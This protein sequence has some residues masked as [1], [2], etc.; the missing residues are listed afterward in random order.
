MFTR[1]TIYKK[2]LLLI[3]LPLVVQATFLGLLIRSQLATLASQEWAFHTKQVIA[4]VSDVYRILSDACSAIGAEL[5]GSSPSVGST[6]R[7]VRQHVLMEID[8]L[9]SLVSDNPLQGMRVREFAARAEP[10][11]RWLETQ[12]QLISSGRN[13][14][15]RKRVQVGAQLLE[16]LRSTMRAIL[17][18]EKSLDQKRMEDLRRTTTSSARTAVI[19]GGA[20]LASTLA[21]SLVF[22]HGLLKRLA[23]LRDNARRFSEG[24]DLRVPMI[25]RDE[26]SD[27][28]RAFH[29][30]AAKLNQQKQENDLF[31]YSVSHDLRSPLVNLQGFSEE[32]S[33]SCAELKSLFHRADVPGAVSQRGLGLLSENVEES[34]RYIHTAVGRLARIIDALL[35]LSRAGRVVYQSQMTDVSS[36]VG[37]IV[38]S[39]HDSISAARA[40]VS[41]GRLPPAWGDPAAIEKIFANL[42]ANA[43][44]YLDSKRP[45]RIEVG[46]VETNGAQAADD[47]FVYFVRDN[48]LGIPEPYHSRVFTPF[49]RLHADVAQGEGVGLALVATVVQRLGGR[50]WLNSSAGVGSTFFVALPS[51]SLAERSIAVDGPSPCN[52]RPEAKAQNGI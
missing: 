34:I 12:E 16:D 49:N 28:D 15:A 23:I 36:I 22:F 35:R 43:V 50:I 19:G 14:G 10:V 32:L 24:E 6:F 30:M 17:A 26:I 21:L 27:V 42:I 3:A 9:Q 8:E 48:G 51:R 41:V 1:L 52:A 39:L 29:D 46:S 40:E 11:L 7:L 38:D 44:Q 33:Y 20:V 37:R 18:E 45:G 13:D 2:G 4:K 25:A 31:V 47:H 5:V